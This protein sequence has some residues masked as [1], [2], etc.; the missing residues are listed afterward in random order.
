MLLISSDSMTFIYTEKYIYMHLS[1]AS[2][3]FIYRD[4][5]YDFYIYILYIYI[6]MYN[7]SSDIYIYT[8]LRMIN[9]SPLEN[10]FLYN[11]HT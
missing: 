10:I 9:A 1:S 3:T 11:I 6:Y 8:H 5:I 2:M 4:S 7:A